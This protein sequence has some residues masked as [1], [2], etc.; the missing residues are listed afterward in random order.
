MVDTGAKRGDQ[1]EG[2]TGGGQH[3][4]VDSVGDGGHQDIGPLHGGDQLRL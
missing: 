4:G 1:L 3:L 2:G